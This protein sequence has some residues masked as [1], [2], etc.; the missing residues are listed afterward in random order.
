VTGKR[1]GKK[2]APKRRKGPQYG[3]VSEGKHKFPDPALAFQVLANSIA[4]VT[5]KARALDD[6]MAH[7]NW[8]DLAN[9]IEQSEKLIPHQGLRRYVV[10][11]L[12]K[13]I[14]QPRNK[15]AR[16]MTKVRN[17]EMAI[18]SRWLERK[19]SVGDAIAK[20]ADDFGVDERI[21]QEARRQT[22]PITNPEELVTAIGEG[23]RLSDEAGE[24]AKP[25][26]DDPRWPPG[27]RKN[28]AIW[29]TKMEDG[30]LQ[31]EIFVPNE[32][33]RGKVPP[34]LLGEDK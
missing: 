20:V 30:T 32:M 33:L 25:G 5:L 15:P 27:V 24:H 22:P 26:N 21:V 10:G 9:C 28:L 11:V 12:R 2:I 14:T 4:A 19:M 6:A 1:I 17:F 29:M 18:Q 7:G 34:K 3:L 8:T 13:K 23:I 16:A 31:V